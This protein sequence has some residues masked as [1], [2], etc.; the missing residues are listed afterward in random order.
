MTTL[1]TTYI[2]LL[3]ACSCLAATVL[4]S[5]ARAAEVLVIGSP[6]GDSQV[7]AQAIIASMRA[8]AADHPWLGLSEIDVALGSSADPREAVRQATRQALAARSKFDE[9][10]I[11]DA[12]KLVT[13]ALNGY[14]NNVS[15]VTD[16]RPLSHALELMAA[17]ALTNDDQKTATNVIA[18]MV[19][20]DP[21]G[22]PSLEL[23]NPP[24]LKKWQAIAQ[25]YRAQHKET[26]VV[27]SSNGE[28]AIVEIDGRFRGLTPFVAKDVLPG[29]HYVR[30]SRVGS[31]PWGSVVNVGNKPARVTPT[32]ASADNARP[33]LAARDE[34][35][36]A[37]PETR[38]Q[39]LQ[40]LGALLPVE[41]LVLVTA[42]QHQAT[43]VA[44]L[45]PVHAELYSN[46]KQRV[47]RTSDAA[48]G[49]RPGSAPPLPRTFVDGIFPPAPHLTLTGTITSQSDNDVVANMKHI[50]MLA[51]KTI[52]MT[53][54]R[55][56]PL[57]ESACLT[58]ATCMTKARGD[59]DGII[60]AHVVPAG[61]QDVSVTL[62]TYVGAN[63]VGQ[64]II[65]KA[66]A[67]DVLV[68]AIADQVSHAFLE[69][70]NLRVNGQIIGTMP[71]DGSGANVTG[72]T[73]TTPPP[74]NTK[75]T[76][77]IITASAGLGFAVA[78]FTLAG[79]E[80]GVLNDA[81]STGAH[82]DS[83]RNLGRVGVI[84]GGVGVAALVVGTVLWLTSGGK[85]ESDTSNEAN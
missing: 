32:L 81:N 72:V 36:R 23:Y 22:S 4:A 16:M 42:T 21:D 10:L 8:S 26:L 1:T 41:Y 11:E 2:R 57:L 70:E 78:G 18:E 27:E 64:V 20:L 54:V 49:V 40:R 6:D 48:F 39:A 59:T 65:D 69:I 83:A 15:R 68:S 14:R 43:G 79:V 80:S 55:E 33:F 46:S 50:I 52:E 76:V 82:K 34:V 17:I 74:G 35:F 7:A 24:M 61:K 51:L 47:L 25:R 28:A 9:L 66:R 19:A 77:G 62:A 85:S 58:D 56:I 75:R 3:V 84:A 37:S 30:V 45:T 38:R 12:D 31:V 13:A 44:A 67:S 60:V 71:Q 5:H 73:A 53:D 63:R 29:A